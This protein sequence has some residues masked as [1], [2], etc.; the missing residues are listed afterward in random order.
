MMMHRRE[1]DEYIRERAIPV[2]APTVTDDS[3]QT[4]GMDSCTTSANGAS[5]NVFSIGNQPLSPNIAAWYAS[6]GFIGYQMCAII[7]QNWLVNKACEKRG[8]DA[9]SKWFT[10]SINDGTDADKEIISFIEK[11]NKC[12]GLK[13]NLRQAHKFNNVFGIRHVLFVVDS[14]DPLYYEKPF[15]PDGIKAGTYKGMQQIDPYWIAP[16]LTGDAVS[17]PT[18][19]DFYE[20]EHWVVSGKKIHKSH[21]IILRGAEVSDFLK[22]SYLY[23]G[24]PLTQ[25]IY[26]RVYAAERTANEA[27]Q[28]AMTKRLNVY[29]VKDMKAAIA[30]PQLLNEANQFL[31]QQRDNY[32]VLY[33]SKD[34]DIQQLETSLTDLD[35]TIMTQYQ[36][37]ASESNTPAT[38]LL[39]TSPKGFNATGEHEIESY[40]EE[41]SNVQENEYDHI[42]ERHIQCLMKSEV[43][44]KFK[45]DAEITITWNPLST[46]TRKE[47]AEINE[48]NANT[49]S[50]LVNATG[51]IS[52]DEVR[53]ALIADE[54]SGFSGL[55]AI[56]DDNIDEPLES[57]FPDEPDDSEATDSAMAM[58]FIRKSE[59]KYYV[60]SEAGKRLSEGYKNKQD[61]I[62][63]LQEIEY[64][65]HA[66]DESDSSDTPAN[67]S[68][69]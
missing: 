17:D 11:K 25:R 4:F 24:I 65:K 61:A 66:D 41:L 48:T 55:T 31:S 20:P 45:T 57:E 50:T 47:R 58:D 23:G 6:Q 5:C 62:K 36:L 37:V 49:Y 54:H 18:N 59:G 12:M 26:E 38:E 1:I 33:A 29:K 69:S 15:N 42:V 34:E 21:F 22:P 52:P 7:A 2:G 35:A 46:E 44:P 51:A 19:M 43:I 8:K 28:L 60:Y 14:S 10:M 27:P 56:D 30:N 40:H 16:N 68:D 67:E 9:V 64:F 32:G 39:G 53:D 13:K 3:G 63:R